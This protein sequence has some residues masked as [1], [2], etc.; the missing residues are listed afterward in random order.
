MI[1]KVRLFS[2]SFFSSTAEG[3]LIVSTLLQLSPRISQTVG[4]LALL[5]L[6]KGGSVQPLPRLG[7][8]NER[9]IGGNEGRK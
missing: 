8:L 9:S 1:A 7:V 4:S 5:V 2:T 3:A 6:Q